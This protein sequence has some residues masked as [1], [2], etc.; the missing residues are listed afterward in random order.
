VLRVLTFLLCAVLA[1]TG[2]LAETRVAFVVGNAAYEHAGALANPVN[3]A[4]DVATLLEKLNFDVV[5][6]V[7][8]TEDDFG[9]KLAEF[10]SKLQTAD[11]ALF[12]YAGHGIQYEGENYLIPVDA[13]LENDIRVRRETMSLEEV[14]DQMQGTKVRLVFID[15]CRNNPFAEK[16]RSASVG[17]NRALSIGRGLALPSVSGRDMLIAFAAEPDKVAADGTGRNSPFTKAMLRHLPTPGED[18]TSVLRLVTSDVRKET[19]GEQSPQQVASMETNFYMVPRDAGVVP[20]QPVVDTPPPSG[21]VDPEQFL[22]AAAER[23]GTAE[24]WD[25]FLA[26]YPNSV[27]KGVAEAHLKKLRTDVA[28]IDPTDPPVVEPEP[29]KTTDDEEIATLLASAMTAYGNRRYEDAVRHYTAAVDL[30]SAIAMGDLAYLTEQ[31]LGTSKSPSRAVE[32]YLRAIEAGNAFAAYNYA[33][34]LERGD[35]ITRNPSEAAR[36]LVYSLTNGTSE[37]RRNI[38]SALLAD[39]GNLG[40]ETRKAL[41]QE[42]RDRGLYS[43]GIDGSFGPASKAA[44][45]RLAGGS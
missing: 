13:A 17:T 34:M 18:I 28:S 24:A 21:G 25:A 4:T 29:P 3:D 2:A 33:W 5:L 11:V 12:Y 19:N 42:L 39:V 23:A 35:G 45:E 30:G 10:A 15:A 43:D 14:V 22:F 37:S 41:Q 31:G 7:D 44:L 8:L 1:T 38:L 20:T 40:A 6:G 26:A 9:N 32:L 36:R 16:M 27:L